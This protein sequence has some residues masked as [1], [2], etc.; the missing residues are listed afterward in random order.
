MSYSDFTRQ[1]SRLEICNLTP[2]TLES[3]DVG[4]WNHYQYEGMWRVGSTAGGC[5]N[6]AGNGG[7]WTCVQNRVLEGYFFEIDH[8]YVSATFTSNP[9]FMVRLED[10]DD[11]P[12][13]GE[14]GCTF[15]LGLMQKDGRR[16]KML[17]RNLETIGFAIYKVSPY[18][19][20]FQFRFFWINILRKF[21]KK[22]TPHKTVY[23]LFA[24]ARTGMRCTL[25]SSSLYHQ[26]LKCLLQNQEC[27]CCHLLY[28]RTQWTQWLW[29]TFEDLPGHP[30]LRGRGNVHLGPDILLRQPAVAM[31]STFINTRE[32]CDRFK[33]P[34]GEYAIIPSTF[35]PHKN[36]SFILRVFSEKQAKTR[37]LW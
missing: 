6:Y 3:D 20:T 32:V 31:S 29:L 10:V 35:Q 1:F 19:V 30:Q 8:L 36:G 5:L 23:F 25:Q 16:Q 15:L 17:D 14:N 2:D 11:D 21:S 12:L 28:D 24:G 26:W 13:D 18:N 37:Y 34:P 27:C 9:Q 4:H 22:K 33:L 7:V